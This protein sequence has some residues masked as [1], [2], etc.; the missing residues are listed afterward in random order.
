MVTVINKTY[1]IL[2]FGME[3]LVLYLLLS[4]KADMKKDQKICEPFMILTKSPQF[5]RVKRVPY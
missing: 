1:L 2:F 5:F 3:Q 4:Y